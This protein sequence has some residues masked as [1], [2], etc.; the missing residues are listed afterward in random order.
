MLQSDNYVTMRQSLRLLEDILVDRHNF[1]VM[2]VVP[3][4]LFRLDPG[5]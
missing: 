1:Q 3:P 5:G 2:C 4:S